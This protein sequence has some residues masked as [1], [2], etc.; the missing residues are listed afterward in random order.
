MFDTPV[1]GACWRRYNSMHVK[2]IGIWTDKGQHAEIYI[3]CIGKGG[4]E[5]CTEEESAWTCKEIKY[6]IVL[7]YIDYQSAELNQIKGN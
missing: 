6:Q 2:I 7:V 3:L 5:T 4:A 1:V